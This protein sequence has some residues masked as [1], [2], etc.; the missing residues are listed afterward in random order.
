MNED[1]NVVVTQDNDYSEQISLLLESQEQTNEQL[2]A[3]VTLLNKKSAA[4]EIKAKEEAEAKAQA[5]KDAEA[6][7]KE[8]E[9]DEQ[10]SQAKAETQEQREVTQTESLQAVQASVDLTNHIM[11]G[12][13]CFLG[14]LLGVLLMKI[15]WDRFHL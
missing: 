4:D 14:V 3:I 12:Q 15:F 1:E 10:D 11:A 13:I 7:E 9:K 8:A 6:A 5:A 2:Q